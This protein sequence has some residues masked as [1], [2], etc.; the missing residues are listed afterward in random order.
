MRDSSQT[1]TSSA[2]RFFSGTLISRVTGLLREIAMASAFGT[3]TSV[4]AF[5]MAFRFA[6]LLRRL[7]GEGALNTAFIPH[8]E[9]IRKK[10][11]HSAAQFYVDLVTA[12][13]ALLVLIVVM[14]EIVLGYFLFFTP[15]GEGSQ[16]VLSLTMILLPSSIFISLYALNHSFLNCEQSYFL[17]SLAPSFFNIIWIAALFLLWRQG[18]L[19]MDYLALLI[20]FAFAIQ[21]MVTLPQSSSFLA[22]YPPKR[23][24]F[25]KGFDYRALLAIARPFALGTIGVTAT[26]INSA[27]D[28]IFARFADLEGPAYL[29]YAIRLQQLPLALFGV[30]LA[31]ALLP[32]LS[33]AMQHKDREKSRFFIHFAMKQQLLVMIPL[34]AALFALSLSAVDLIYG[35][36]E[37]SDRA[38]LQ[39]TSC[40]WAYGAGLFPMTAILILVAPFY[41]DKNYRLPALLSLLSVVLNILLNAFFLFGVRMEAMSV[42][43]ATTIAAYVNLFLLVFFLKKREMLLWTGLG[44]LLLKLLLCSLVAMM[45]TVWLGDLLGDNTWRWLNGESVIFQKDVRGQVLLFSVQAF[46]FGATFILTA[47]ICRFEEFLALARFRRN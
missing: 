30:G 5:W 9:S 17:P 22:Q 12:V 1:I 36:G 47:F 16:E 44:G 35:H 29:W 23:G 24:W 32:P 21:W 14:V 4:A 42:A 7:F 13:T 6:S 8:F 31:S 34:T 3:S 15:L 39:T 43:L 18:L 46:C 37:F 2:K 45:A 11:P 25:V 40:L 41:A 10:D 19:Q 38:V 20:V 33:R 26:Q 28:A 27:L